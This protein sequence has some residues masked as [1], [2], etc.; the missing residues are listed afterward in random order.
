LL[1]GLVSVDL[2]KELGG[3]MDLKLELEEVVEVSLDLLMRKVD[4]H[5]CDL[6]SLDLANEGL[7]KLVD[8]LS[9]ELLEVGVVWD[10]NWHNL[11]SSLVVCINEL[12]RVSK[13]ALR[14]LDHDL[15]RGNVNCLGNRLHNWLNLRNKALV[16]VIGTLTVSPLTTLGS[17]AAHLSIVVVWLSVVVVSHAA[18]VHWVAVLVVVVV[19]TLVWESVSTHL[20]LDEEQNL[21]DELDGIRA[22]EDGGIKRSC[23]LPLEVHEVSLVLSV[24]LLLLADLWEFVVGYVEEL[25]INSLGL[26]EG[27]TSRSRGVG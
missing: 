7:Y 22:S 19:A 6:R 2:N 18:V 20:S 1:L 4:K 8:E 14:V 16:L 9:N 13:W 3:F 24:S 23:T 25:S 27:S 10:Y 11:E 15:S 12:F 17:V 5:A 26:M 21:L